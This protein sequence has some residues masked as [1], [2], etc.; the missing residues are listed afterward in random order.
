M[1]AVLQ[2]GI[3]EL[4]VA[5]LPPP[6]PGP[7]EVLL[8]LRAVTICAS[9]LHI[10]AEG[11]VGG[12]SWDRP[13]VPGHEAAG[14]VE[15]SRGTSLAVGAPVVIDPAIPCRAC[16][17]CDRGNYHLCRHLR[18]CDLP[19]TDGAMQELLAWPASQ[20]FRVPE[21]LDL[22]LAPLIEPLCV[23]VHATELASHLEGATVAVLGCGAVGLCTVQMARV[24][25]AKRI[26]AVDPIP[27]RR[28]VAR[29]LGADEVIPGGGPDTATHLLSLTQGRG[30]DV[31]FE[32]AGPLEAVQQCLDVVAPAGEVVVIGIPSEDSYSLRPSQLRRRELTLRF[33]RRQN[34]NFPEAISLVREGKVQLGPMLTHRFPMAQVQEAFE[35]AEAKAEGAVRVAVVFGE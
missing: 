9:D 25:G 10:Y 29:A 8:R 23:G 32:A 26:F 2:Y 14:V 3:R 20:V 4:R 6:T 7:G 24:R 22:T 33:C 34:D 13:F 5:E 35:F 27:E 16:E 12:V 21:V 30:V 17:Q 19:P 1:Q 28:A 18:F 31:A 15:D 11:N